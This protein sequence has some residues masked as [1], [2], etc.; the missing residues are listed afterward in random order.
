MNV[1]I[2]TFNCNSI[3][4]AHVGNFKQTIDNAMKYSE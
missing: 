2:G 1:L 4:K 3:N